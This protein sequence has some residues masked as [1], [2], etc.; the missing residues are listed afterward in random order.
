MQLLI[1]HPADMT[2][3]LHGVEDGHNFVA[4]PIISSPV[5]GCAKIETT[6]Q[7]VEAFGEEDGGHPAAML[8]LLI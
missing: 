6:Q 2:G 1:L 5:G 3:L 4:H 8:I 7:L